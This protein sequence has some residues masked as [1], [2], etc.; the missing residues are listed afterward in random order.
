LWGRVADLHADLTPLAFLVGTWRGVG[1]GG[2]PT[3][4]SFRYAQELAITHDG[5]PFLMLTSR[6]WLLDDDG[7]RVRPL[8]VESGFWRPGS[9]AVV[10]LV[11]AHG[12]G[13]AEIWLGVVRATTVTLATD[14]VARTGTAKEV[15]GGRRQYALADGE[16]LTTYD[17]AALG[18]PLQPHLS[19]RLLPV[20]GDA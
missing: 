18:Q 1:V 2:Y 13:F 16:L 15:T 9:D 12:A 11:L 8:A 4:E 10:E 20:D 5:R 6:S 7:A 14:L 3:I 19:A 17:M